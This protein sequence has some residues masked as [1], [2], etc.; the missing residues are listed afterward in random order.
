MS[1]TA[2]RGGAKGYLLK[3]ADAEELLSVRPGIFG[4]W[5]SLGHRRPG[6]PERTRVEL[7]YV[8]TRSLAHDVRILARSL[9][10]VIRGADEGG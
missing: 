8:R 7:E 9:P 10:V 2:V 4:A 3:D 6:Y 5:T 1:T